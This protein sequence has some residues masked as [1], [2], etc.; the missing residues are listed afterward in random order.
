MFAKIK[1]FIVQG[2]ALLAILLAA[3]FLIPLRSAADTIKLP[4]GPNN[5]FVAVYASYDDGSSAYTN[6]VQLDPTGNGTF[7]PSDQSHVSQLI[8]KNVGTT[9]P[10]TLPPAN[11]FLPQNSVTEATVFNFGPGGLDAFAGLELPLFGATDSA[12]S[13]LA[14][15]DVSALF[16]AGN[17]FTLGETLTVV[18]GSSALSNA[19][20][21]LD[22]ATL[23]SVIDATAVTAIADPAVLAGLPLFT[24]TVVVDFPADVVPEPST[25]LLLSVG[26]PASSFTGH[27][28]E[29]DERR[30]VN[31]AEQE[32]FDR[33]KKRF[34]PDRFR[35]P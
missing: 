3:I 13:V 33:L 1:A 30:P 10:T 25:L 5:G 31:A 32:E 24:G 26:L 27:C 29:H 9:K 17:P 7:T 4:V 28:A 16:A 34:T 14:I 18:N 15:I 21:F 6:V 11:F 20:Q 2:R 22:A 12:L 35:H 19:V 8:A 23:G